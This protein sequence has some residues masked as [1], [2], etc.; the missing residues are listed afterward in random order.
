MATQYTAGLTT[1]QVLT[2]ATMNSIGAAYETYTPTWS[3]LTVGNGTQAF[4]YGRINKLVYGYG[5]LTLGS[6]SSVTGP[7]TFTLPVTARSTVVW[8]NTR[9]TDAGNADYQGLCG[10]SS[11][12]AARVTALKTDGTYLQT[13]ALSSTV[14]FT[15]GSTDTITVYFLYEAA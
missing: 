13:V 4:Y 7:V 9:L 1:G 2:A 8:G 3:G 11:T 12:T 15:W 5:T 6:T 10:D 14:P